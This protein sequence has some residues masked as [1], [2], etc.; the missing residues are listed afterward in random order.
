MEKNNQKKLPLQLY[1]H[2]PFCVKKCAY[3][4]FLSGPAGEETQDAYVQALKKEIHGIQEGKER[5]VS[6]VFIGGG[7][8]SLLKPG[9][10]ESIMNQLYRE[11]LITP[12]AEIT[13]EANPGTFIRGE[14]SCE[15][16][17]SLSREK[18]RLYRGAG[19]NRL[20]MGLQ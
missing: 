18:L 19:I 12:D 7:T 14:N 8:P 5:P 2:I 9:H 20:S 4:D 6:S 17:K 13:I 10:I 3:C 15:E 1:V 11:F 16:Q